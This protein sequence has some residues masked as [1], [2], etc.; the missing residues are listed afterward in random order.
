M[1][2]IT[3]AAGFVGRHLVQALV[4]QQLGQ[5]LRLLDVR[6]HDGPIPIG[7]EVVKATIESESDVRAAMRGVNVVIHLAAF[8]QP[9]SPDLDRMIR[10]NEGGTRTLFSA[11]VAAGCRHFVHISSAGIYGPPRGIDPLRESDGARPSSP[12]QLTKWA[13]EEALRGIPAGATTLNIVRPT[14]IYGA[15]SQLELPRYRR[16]LRR[17]WSLGLQGEMIVNPVHVSDFIAAIVAIVQ[18]PAKHGSVF[19][20][21]GE[22][23]IMIGELDAL[24]ATALGVTH[25]RIILPAGIAG[26]LARIVQPLSAWLGRPNPLF[27]VYAR[28]DNMSVVVDDLLFRSCYPEV[29]RLAIVDG[30]R[31]HVAWARAEGLI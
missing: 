21:G 15:G 8:V 28:G 11:A 31:G 1:I 17:R 25:R 14:G 10:V 20:I 18:A 9:S 3:G 30:I 12:Y 29:G 5:G 27:R 7:A 24:I 2:L 22:R 23:P 16:L 4:P 26:P 6:P 19:N 13:A